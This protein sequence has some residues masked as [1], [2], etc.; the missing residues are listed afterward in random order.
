MD[1]RI[2]LIDQC[3]IPGSIATC[4][5]QTGIQIMFGTGGTLEAIL[6]AAAVKCL[7]GYMLAQEIELSNDKITYSNKLLTLDKLIKGH[8]VYAATGITHGNILKGVRNVDYNTGPITQS[9]F[10]RSISGTT[11]IIETHHGN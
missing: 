2:K 9:I 7:K 4:L 10:M 8:C 6:T 11:R 3:D 1:I 5:P